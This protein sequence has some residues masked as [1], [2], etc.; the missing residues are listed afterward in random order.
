MRSFE[1]RKMRGL[2]KKKTE[3]PDD[4]VITKLERLA[5]LLEKELL[6]PEEFQAQKAKL[7]GQ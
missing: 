7:L 6:T 3:T 5:A 4:D 1:I 2:D